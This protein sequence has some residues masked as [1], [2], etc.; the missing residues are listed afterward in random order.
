MNFSLHIAVFV[1]VIFIGFV[2]GVVSS[3]KDDADPCDII[4]NIVNMEG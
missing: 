1:T 2:L 4:E 3:R